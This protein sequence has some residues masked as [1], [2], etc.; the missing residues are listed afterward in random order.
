MKLKDLFKRQKEFSDLFF[1]TEDMSEEDKIERHK[2]FMLALH[3]EVSSLAD[4]VHYKDHRP[5]RSN[6]DRQKILY[7][8]VDIMRYCLAVLNLWDVKPKEFADAYDSREAFL[9]DRETN[10]L[11]NWSGQPVVV[12]DVDD[13]LS[14]FRKDFFEWLKIRFDVELDLEDESYYAK[15]DLGSI[16]NEAAFMMFIEEGGI[17]NLTKNKSVIED[18]RRLQKEGFWIHLLTARPSDNLKCAYDTYYWLKKNDIPYNSVAMSPEK[19]RWL[20][21]KSFFKKNKLVCA[22]D[23]SPKHAAEYASQGIKVLVPQRSYNKEVWHMDNV[24]TFDWWKDSAYEKIRG[25]LP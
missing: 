25:I 22:I 16:T 21:D 3:S 15:P 19:Y 6:T 11:Q 8:S 1:D 23:D 2:T 20:T 24:I 17:R 5:V 4:A 7:E 9:W 18:I 12:V 10:G 13:V 14:Q